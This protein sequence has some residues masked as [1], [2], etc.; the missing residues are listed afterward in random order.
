[1]AK[2]LLSKILPSGLG[3]DNLAIKIS[4]YFQGTGLL[5]P[6]LL[7]IPAKAGIRMVELNLSSC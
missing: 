7:V 6:F 4:F 3:R 1:M 2:K 5:V